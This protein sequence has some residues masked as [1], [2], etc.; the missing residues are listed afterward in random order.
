MKKNLVTKKQ[1][2]F[3]KYYFLPKI[4]VL[5]TVKKIKGH[6]LVLNQSA[7]ADYFK[8]DRRT[9]ADFLKQAEIDGLITFDKKVRKVDDKM[10][11][12]ALRRYI[13]PEA[14]HDDK[15]YSK[16]QE[17]INEYMDW[18]PDFGI[19][20]DFFYDFISKTEDNK[21]EKSIKQLEKEEKAKKYASVFYWTLPIMEKINDTRPEKLKSKYLGEGR[22]RESNF[23][24]AT[25]NPEKDH[26]IKLLQADLMYRYMV[27]ED[28]FGTK[29][30]IECDT[31]ASIYRLSYNLVHDKL[32]ADNV[33][34]YAEFWKLAGF[35][36]TLDKVSRDGLKLMC[37]IIFMSNGAKNGYNSVLALKDDKD[38]SRSEIQRKD[39]LNYMA[40]KTSLNV[41]QF[42]DKL[43]EAMYKFLGVD[44]FLEE[45][46]FIY[47]SNLHLLILEE[48][49][50][51]NIPVINVYDGFYFKKSD[52]TQSKYLKLYNESTLK[53]KAICK[54]AVS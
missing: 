8:M 32:L 34:V 5:L 44:T 6:D 38:L 53:L 27:L 52:M 13:L 30:F 16:L 4:E 26:A 1:K 46:I 28:F 10:L 47:E 3:Y 9:V 40:K 15:Y 11:D 24:C 48:C 29:A 12:K 36:G 22:L 45:E 35:K 39:V 2:D 33:D 19:R 18:T 25:L 37:M 50:K 23:L 49:E 31:N 51:R 20:L 43:T 41:R 54:N 42:L 14:E 7:I 21:V 17:H